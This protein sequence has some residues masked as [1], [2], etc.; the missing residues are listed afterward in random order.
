[1]LVFAHLSFAIQATKTLLLRTLCWQEFSIMEKSGGWTL[2]K[3]EGH[4]QGVFLLA[5]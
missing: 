3:G 4:L 1:M 5:K 2:L